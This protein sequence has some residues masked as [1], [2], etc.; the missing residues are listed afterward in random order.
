MIATALLT[1]GAVP[2]T[3]IAA[4]PAAASAPSTLTLDSLPAWHYQ[5]VVLDAE[6]LRYRPHDDVIFPS[7]VATEGRLAN[8]LGRYYLY[9]A[10]HDAPGGICL[11]YADK[12]TGPWHEYAQNPLISRAWPPHYTVSH[13]S[14]P[15][16]IWS[17]EDQ[18]L[19]LYFH[20]ENDVT[21]LATSADGLHFE[22]DREVV[23]TR[24]FPGLTEASYGR[25]FRHALPRRDNRYVMLLM[26]NDHGTRRIYLATSPDG[27]Q[28]TARPG[29][30][31]DPPPGTDQLAA[32]VLVP[33]GGKLF[34]V[35]HAHDAKADFNLGNDLYAWSTDAA[36][37]T[38]KPLGKCVDRSLAGADNPSVMSPCFVAEGDKLYLFLNTGPRLKNK[39]ALAV[40]TGQPLKDWPEPQ[41]ILRLWPGDASGLVSPAKSESILNQRVRDVSVPELWAY[42]PP[43][44]GQGRAALLICPGGGYNHLAIGLHVAHVLELFHR[45]D[46]VVFCVKYRTHYGHNDPAADSA[47]DLARAVRLV[48]QRAAEWGVDPARIGV[49]GYSAG[50][51]CCLNLLCRWEPG[52]PA[53]TDPLD[54]FSSR[55]DF[56]ALMSLWSAGRPAAAFPTRDNPPPTFIASAEDDKTAPTAFSQAIA[57]RLR[58]QGGQVELFIV[59]TGGHSAFHYGAEKGPGQGWPTAFE[60]VLGK[61]AP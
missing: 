56:A 14:G 19:L 24:L 22:Y 41:Q 61:H 1:L 25:V 49:Q 28:W 52:N 6:Q 5:G 58:Q 16:A 33:W 48:R 21:R 54:R 57:A 51:N 55:P 60:K 59:P 4:A 39:I 45:Q 44:A 38:I 31:L 35:A 47:A 15:D 8:P 13:V 9:Y 50:A 17:P 30:L 40:S 18:R 7:V 29:A 10:P 27:R 20:G 34:L 11:A 2:W 42:P 23:T 3:A 53:A 43:R 37:E 46:V 12:L 32:A 36:L 26:G